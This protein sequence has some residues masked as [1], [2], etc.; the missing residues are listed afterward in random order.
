MPAAAEPPPDPQEQGAGLL[1]VAVKPWGNVFV[2][3]K[4]MGT[5]PLDKI[6][7]TA[8]GHSIRCEHPLYE[9]IQGK[10]T[11]RAG[12]TSKL[13]FDFTKDGVRKPQD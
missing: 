5:T 8:G 4:L 7:L 13:G 1:Q 12:E 3:G 9:P 6:P 2:D 11:V 10:V